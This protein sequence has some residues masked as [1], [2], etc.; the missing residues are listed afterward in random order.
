MFDIIGKV[1]KTVVH[2]DGVV[3]VDAVY[4]N[5][6]GDDLDL[7]DGLVDTDEFYLTHERFVYGTAVWSDQ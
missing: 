3:E 2:P 5:G 1:C 4:R 7:H 6:K